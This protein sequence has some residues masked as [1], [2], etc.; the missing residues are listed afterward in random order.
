MEIGLEKLLQIFSGFILAMLNLIQ[1]KMFWSNFLPLFFQ[2][3]KEL[4]AK[5]PKEFERLLDTIE[6]YLRLAFSLVISVFY[7]KNLLKVI[8]FV[9]LFCIWVEHTNF[10]DHFFI[11]SKKTDMETVVAA[12]QNNFLVQCRDYSL[13][14]QSCSYSICLIFSKHH[15]LFLQRLME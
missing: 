3:G 11:I 7:L 8:S 12:T 4:S 9:I 14:A 15:H 1:K 13:K 2:C 10:R 6:S 5:K